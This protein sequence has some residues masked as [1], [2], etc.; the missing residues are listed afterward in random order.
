MLFALAAAILGLGFQVHVNI[1]SGPLFRRFAAPDDIE[2]LMPVFWIGF[3]LAALPAGWLAGRWGR[4]A[5]GGGA[6]LVGVAAVL[7]ARMAGSLE[8]VIAAQLVTGAAWGDMVTSLIA[9]APAIGGKGHEGFALGLTFSALALATLAR[10]SAVAGGLPADP[11][12]AAAL[13][14]TPALSWSAG[15]AV[16]LALAA[17]VRPR[18]ET[19]AVS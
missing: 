19:V 11:A 1:A 18:P 3:S 9:A 14:W 16:L 17:T 5:V 4:L 10:M 13:A 15:G 2:L 8:A 6:G 7:A 12:Y